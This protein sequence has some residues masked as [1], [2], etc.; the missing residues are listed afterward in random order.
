ARSLAKSLGTEK[1]IPREEIADWQPL[2][3]YCHGNPLTLL[4]IVGQAIKMGLRGKEPIGKFVEAIRSGEQAIE[5]ADE[6]QGRDK[7]LGASLDY[8]FRN[9]FQ[10]DEQPIIALLNL[11]QG[12]VVVE[13]L[14]FMGGVGDH[15]LPELKGKTKEHLTSLL[16]RAKDTGLL[17]HLGGTW[18]TIHPALPWFLRQLFARHYDGQEGRSTA[19]AALRAWVE[20]IGELGNYYHTQFEHGNREVIQILAL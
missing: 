9:A 15:A 13:A 12:S 11:F 14:E 3:D 20:A 7:S 8:G 2:L 18:Y 17:T 5:D 1:E 4:I 16:D 19:T 10:P 6:K